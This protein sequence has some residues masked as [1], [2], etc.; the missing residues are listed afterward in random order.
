MFLFT[1]IPQSASPAP[2]PTTS[3][4]PVNTALRD[5]AGR[6]GVSFDYLVKTAQRE[7][8][9]DPNAK[10]PGSSA[11]GLFQFLEQTWLGLVK[12]DGAK[13]GMA[14]VSNAV[15]T[16]GDGKLTIT[17]PDLKAKVLSLR[18]NPELAATAAGV[19]T[20]KN[21]EAL[22]AS[23][24]RE[25][26]NGELYIAHFLGSSGASQLI[27]LAS[28]K[29]E[30]KAASYFGDA[31]SA[32][33]SIFYEKSGRPRTTSEVYFSLIAA[34]ENTKAAAMPVQVAAAAEAP[35]VNN[36]VSDAPAGKPLLGLFRS[37][38]EGAANSVRSTWTGLPRKATMVEGARASYFPRTGTVEA[39][40]GDEKPA[41]K[42]SVP[43]ATVPELKA[44]D[45]PLPPSRPQRSSSATVSRTARALPMPLDLLSFTRVKG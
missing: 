30:A 45:V 36:V 35:P 32:N 19:F 15:V 21:R 34:H 18:E 10:A 39:S 41:E 3:D 8:S 1:D 28:V 2:A 25:P 5:A 14:D 29:P 12:S 4:T 42:A 27:Q 43:Q 7:S 11:S 6:T 26:S 44:A 40:F 13:L 38:P 33:R 22:T 9:L 20:T 17:D 24:G 37:L 31:A 23:L 16:T